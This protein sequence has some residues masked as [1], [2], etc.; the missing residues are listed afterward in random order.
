MSTIA[1]WALRHS[2]REARPYSA[3]MFT[4]TMSISCDFVG[5]LALTGVGAIPST[6]FPMTNLMA[7]PHDPHVD[8]LITHGIN[9]KIFSCLRESDHQLEGD[10]SLLWAHIMVI[11][12]ATGRTLYTL[13]PFP[14]REV[15]EQQLISDELSTRT[16]A[17]EVAS[18]LDYMIGNV[19]TTGPAKK[20]QF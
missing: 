16:R 14:S 20:P 7:C 17:A 10:R 3:V 5:H 1:T 19:V 18:T 2:V 4:F 13:R 8:G 15:E 9:G 12:D 6:E 11:D